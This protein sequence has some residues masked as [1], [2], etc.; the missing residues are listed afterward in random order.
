MFFYNLHNINK[1]DIEYVKKSL[2]SSNITK[3]EFLKKFESQLCK[4][5]RSKYSLVTTN[6]TSSFYIISKV[7]NWGKNSN[8]IVSPLTF[9]AGA[10]SIIAAGSKPIF[11]DVKNNDQNLDPILV[12]KTIR[13]LKKKKKKIDAI[14]VTD[15]GGLPADWKKFYQIKKNIS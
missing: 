6:A 4:T 15:Y 11:V 7:L 14:I 1:N 8:I 2:K 5:F 12:E 10:N 13:N 9:V 3:G